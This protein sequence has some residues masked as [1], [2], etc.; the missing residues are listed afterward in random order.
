MASIKK[1]LKSAPRLRNSLPQNVT[2]GNGVK[3]PQKAEAYVGKGVLRSGDTITAVKGSITPVPN[4]PLI[5]KKGPFKGSTLKKG[6]KVTV[7]AGGE[8][9]VVYKKTSPT[10]V[11]KGKKGHI[12][13]N[14]PTKDKGKWDTIDLTKIGRAKTVKQGVASTKKWHRD[15]PDYKYK[16]KK[17]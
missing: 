4:G 10:G 14:H 12:M 17:K 6:G 16:G 2:R 8:K 9:H 7:I 3:N 5:K 11:G 15:N 13:V 1:L